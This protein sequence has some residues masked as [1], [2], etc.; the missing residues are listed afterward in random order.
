MLLI[1]LQFLADLYVISVSAKQRPTSDSSAEGVTRKKV[2]CVGEFEI[3]KQCKTLRKLKSCGHSGARI[4]DLQPS[5][6]MKM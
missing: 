6:A 2:I 4:L 1:Y 3:G 5:P